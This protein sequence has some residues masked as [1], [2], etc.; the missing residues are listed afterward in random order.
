[1]ARSSQIGAGGVG[2]VVLA[3]VAGCGSG[4]G[5]LGQ[6]KGAGVSTVGIPVRTHEFAL[7]AIPFAARVI[8]RPLELLG[9]RLLHP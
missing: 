6:P 2:L 5:P 8:D 4:A 7:T 9:V 3:V 1:V